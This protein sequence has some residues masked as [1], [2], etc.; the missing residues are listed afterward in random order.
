M[1]SFLKMQRQYTGRQTDGQ[2][3]VELMDGWADIQMDRSIDRQIHEWTD[4]LTDRQ[5]DPY[6]CFCKR[7]TEKTGRRVLKSMKVEFQGQHPTIIFTLFN[8]RDH[9]GLVNR[10]NLRGCNH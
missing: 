8:V 7:W 2:I 5:S 1:K 9:D 4:R 3:G 10:N 6:Q